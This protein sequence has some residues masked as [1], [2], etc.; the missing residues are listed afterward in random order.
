MANESATAEAFV[1]ELLAQ[2]DPIRKVSL[3]VVFDNACTDG[4]IDT[5]RK[6]QQDDKRIKIVWAPANRCVVDAYVRGYREAIKAGCD[7]ILEI[8]AGFSHQP[9]DLPKFFDVLSTGHYDCLFGSRFCKGGR[10]SEGTL[11]RH[12]ISKGGT[13][14]SNL[15]LGTKLRDMTSGCQ[16]FSRKALQHILNEGIK[17]RGHFFQ[18]EVKAYCKNMNFIEVPIHYKNPSS[19]INKMVLNDAF[20]NLLTLFKKRLSG[21]L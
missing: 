2:C 3:F 9:S 15:L 17:S 5:L 12:V 6:S 4:T 18:T 8:D 10:L 7:W 19:N 13:I 1:K 11:K 20:W 16:L 14:L 21:R